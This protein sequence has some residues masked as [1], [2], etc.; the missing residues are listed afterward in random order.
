MKKYTP[1]TLALTTK[2]GQFYAAKL[3]YDE[4]II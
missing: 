2:P 4:S 3:I 1:Q